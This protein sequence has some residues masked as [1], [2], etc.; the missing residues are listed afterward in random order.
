MA[1]RTQSLPSILEANKAYF[2]SNNIKTAKP[3]FEYCV[4]N[5][6]TLGLAS[7]PTSLGQIPNVLKTWGWTNGNSG[8][9]TTETKVN[10]AIDNAK[11]CFLDAGFKKHFMTL[12]IMNSEIPDLVIANGLDGFKPNP[13]FQVW[14]ASL[15]EI[16]QSAIQ[17][18]LSNDVFDANMALLGI[19]TARR[20]QTKKDNALK[21]QKLLDS[22]L[23]VCISAGYV[24]FKATDLQSSIDYAASLKLIPDNGMVMDWQAQACFI[25]I[26]ELPAFEG[27]GMQ[28]DSFNCSIDSPV[29]LNNW[30]AILPSKEQ[31]RISG[32]NGY[33]LFMPETVGMKKEDKELVVQQSKAN[34]AKR[35]ANLG[36]DIHKA[37]LEYHATYQANLDAQRKAEAE[38][39]AKAK[40]AKQA[41]E[42]LLANPELMAQL[43]AGIPA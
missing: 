16:K 35:T 41:M 12:R 32:D 33:I 25:D 28:Y 9:K 29:E 26:P 18:N 20:I 42:L 6:Q 39:E 36:A 27:T 2:E 15:P 34:Y 31:A 37:W 40:Q 17:G 38:A 4:A 8:V 1:M 5:W 23:A 10:P 13:E 30:K 19:E 11:A 43:L 22:S 14:Y 24:C 21:E 3:I 7:A